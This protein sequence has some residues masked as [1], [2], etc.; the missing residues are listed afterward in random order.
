MGDVYRDGLWHKWNAQ[1]IRCK[2]RKDRNGQDIEFRLTFE[3]WL[4]I[5]VDSGHLHERGCKHGQYVMARFNDVGHYE[6]GNVFIQLAKENVREAHEAKTGKRRGTPTREKTGE[7]QRRT[8]SDSHR[9]NLSAAKKGKMLTR[10]TCPVCFLEGGANALRRF[11]FD[12]CKKKS[13]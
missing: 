5:W 13:T 6:V 4:K 7:S 9:A 2:G 12:A 10:L 3:E 8:L 11:H 1:K